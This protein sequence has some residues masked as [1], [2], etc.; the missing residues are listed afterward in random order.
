MNSGV[1]VDMKYSLFVIL[2]L[3]PAS[4]FGQGVSGSWST[5]SSDGFTSRYGLTS[6]E[7]GGKIYVMGGHTGSVP[8]N[9]LEVYDPSSDSW[10]T[11][12]T[13]G[14]FTRR[15]ELTSSVVNGKIYVLGGSKP[16]AVN[17]VEIFDPSTNIWSTPTTTGNFTKRAWLTSSVFENM[18]YAFGGTAG[19]YSEALN[20]LEVFDPSSKTWSTPSTTG[21]FTPRCGSSSVVIDG[22]IYVFGGYTLNAQ[23][24]VEV[25]NPTTN[26]WS[27]PPIS[28]SFP[29]RMCSAASIVDGKVYIVGGEDESGNALNIFEVYDPAD[30]S[31]TTPVISSGQFIS[32][33]GLTSQS[34][35][36]KIYAMGR[37]DNTDPGI[38]NTNQ[39]FTPAT[40]SVEPGSMILSSISLSPNPTTRIIAV[41]NVP[42][43]MMN[44]IVVNI[45][46]ETVMDLKNLHTPDFTLDLSKLVRG[47]YY[48]RFVSPNS[49]VSKMVVRD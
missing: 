30:N 31:W 40:N 34:V 19:S 41:Q 44:V 9:I 35:N 20:T 14:T 15:Y 6:S 48:I 22:K 26:E 47:T 24:I 18:I 38:L 33:Q 17:T 16:G 43:N 29:A 36:G 39:V 28:Q 11:P 49:V 4:L 42:S 46:G 3:V 7:I 12:Q 32:R 45:L 25:F 13:T 23:Y 37:A 21:T 27:T 5:A 10:S 2:I 1:I 8:C